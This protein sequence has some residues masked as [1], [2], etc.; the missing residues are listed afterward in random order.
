MSKEKDKQDL[1]YDDVIPNLSGNI[2]QSKTRGVFI[3]SASLKQPIDL[4]NSAEGKI[5][6]L[7]VTLP[8]PYLEKEYE[9]YSSYVDIIKEIAEKF[10][11]TQLVLVVQTEDGQPNETEQANI[12]KIKSGLKNGSEVLVANVKQSGNNTFSIWSQDAFLIAKSKNTSSSN[13]KYLIKPY[14]HQRNNRRNDGSIAKGVIAESTLSYTPLN[15]PTPL[16]GGNVLVAEDFVLIGQDEIVNSGFTCSGFYKKFQTFFGD[17]KPLITVFS[18]RKEEKKPVELSTRSAKRGGDTRELF[19]VETNDR[20]FHHDI[21]RWRGKEQPL[22]HID[23]F[24][25]LL[26]RNVQ[27]KQLILVG[28]PVIGF[29]IKKLNEDE[30][31]LFDYQFDD[32]QERIEECLQHLKHDLN[33]NDIQYEIIRNPLPM[34]YYRH[35]FDMSWYWASYNNSLVEVINTDKKTIW[36]PRYATNE[37]PQNPQWNDLKKY[38]QEQIDLLQE[39]DF[40]VHLFNHDF[41]FLARKSGSLHCMTKCLYRSNSIGQLKSDIMSDSKIKLGKK[42]DSYVL[43]NENK[44]TQIKLIGANNG[45]ISKIGCKLKKKGSHLTIE[46]GILDHATFSVRLLCKDDLNIELDEDN[47]TTSIVVASDFRE[48][49]GVQGLTFI[50]NETWVSF[51]IEREM[52]GPDGRK[53]PVD[54]LVVNS[55]P[56]M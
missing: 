38:E 9:P 22:F 20:Q 27:G 54:Y 32:V 18:K 5:A 46:N 19:L 17:E 14:N 7:L 40:Q 23:L 16:E 51:H 24:I 4:L 48:R 39:N 44:E 42:G 49:Y 36:L 21:Y 33:Q 26:G 6:S 11:N 29:D 35:G 50:L 28:K 1:M 55:K 37:H 15:F 41:H 8:Y 30:R 31:Q 34:T 13:L 2:S 52:H 10:D 25:T 47:A 12:D 45:E 3:K 56:D 53:V 43:L